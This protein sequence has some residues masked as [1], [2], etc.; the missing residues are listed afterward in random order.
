MSSPD[1]RVLLVMAQAA[2]GIAGHVAD[3]ATR[4]RQRGCRVTVATTSASAEQIRTRLGP[5]VELAAVLRAGKAIPT[6]LSA[7]HRL[8][9]DADVVHAHGHQAGVQALLAARAL[10]PA[11]P[12]VI[13]WHN[14]LLAGGAAGMAGVAAERLQVAGARLVTG[15]SADLVER[16][17]RLG[18][19]DAQLTPVAADLSAWS[20]EPS[21]AKEELARTHALPRDVPWVLTVSRIAAQKD[22]P[23]LLDAAGLMTGREPAFVVVGSGDPELT[24]QLRSRVHAEELPVHFIGAS[25][26][27]PEFIA[28]AT[29]LAMPSRWEARSLVV[30]E[31]LA[32]GL[33]CVVTDTGG[34]PELVGDAGLVV[35]VGDAAALAAAIERV[36]DDPEVARQLRE[37]GRAR[38]AELPDGDQVADDW[39]ERYRAV[40]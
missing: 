26:R 25:S 22:L 38:A 12:V 20:G 16:A 34:L 2:G 15:A 33:P 11:P 19:H 40:L 37:A 21:A 9:R 27:V 5:G 31:A 18:A 6:G 8:A 1:P 13:T 35:P 24:R 28:A 4:L 39:V 32:G 7:L 30:Q 29:V 14:A 17:R 3:L 36:L 10:R 23:T